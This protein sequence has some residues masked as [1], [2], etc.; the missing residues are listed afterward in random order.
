MNVIDQMYDQNSVGHPLGLD[1]CH[2]AII[3]RWAA[4]KLRINEPLQILLC[5][6]L[7]FRTP[8]LPEGV[9]CNHPCPSVVRWFVGPSVFKYLRDRSKDFFNFL[10]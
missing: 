4:K 6:I 8:G 5:R 3:R 10:Q 1:A 9:L 7:I 2:P